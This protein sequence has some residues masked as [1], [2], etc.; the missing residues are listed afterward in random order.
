MQ[1]NQ[2]PWPFAA[3][4]MTAAQVK[5]AQAALTS[6]S[7][8]ASGTEFEPGKP[9]KPGVVSTGKV[10]PRVPRSVQLELSKKVS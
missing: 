5:M 3:G 6:E 10:Q 8:V 7:R 2:W 4:D 9:A 1:Y